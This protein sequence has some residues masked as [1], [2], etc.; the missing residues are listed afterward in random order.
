M[1]DF[2]I[3][4]KAIK[5]INLTES[6]APFI[7]G[8]MLVEDTEVEIYNKIQKLLNTHAMET[9]H[10]FL[11]NLDPLELSESE[12]NKVNNLYKLG[13]ERGFIS[14]DDD[15]ESEDT[16]SNSQNTSNEEPNTFSVVTKAPPA[17][18]PVKT[19]NINTCAYVILYSATRGGQIK[20][21]E[22]FSNALDTRAAK[23]DVISKLEKAGYQNI[24]ILAI[25]AGDPD[26]CGCNDVYCNNTETVSTDYTDENDITLDE[27][28]NNTKEDSTEKDTSDDKE[29]DKSEEDSTEKD[30]SDNKEDDKSEEISDQE[31]PQLKDSYRKIFKSVMQKCKFFEKCFDDLTIDEKVKFFKTLSTVWNKADPLKFMSDKELESL[32]KTIIKK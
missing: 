32:E 6:A 27:K 18:T 3:W 12:I 5:K 19:Y 14:N 25:E 17:V 15:E 13:I 11:Y 28:E 4:Q 1:N 29:D 22:A 2:E 30:T 31:K 23:A 24:S 20:T 10:P 21:G 8:I 16:D 7:R 26:A 9:S